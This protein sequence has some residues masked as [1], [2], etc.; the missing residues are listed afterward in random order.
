MNSEE[1]KKLEAKRA[2]LKEWLDRYKN[3]HDAVPFVQTNL[4]LTEWEF[5]A[6]SNMPMKAKGVEIDELENIIQRDYEYVQNAL[7]MIPKYDLNLLK[8]S[9]VVN[10][11]GSQV[12]YGYVARVVDLGTPEAE[13]YSNK[14]VALYQNLQ[15]KQQR[16]ERVRE[17]LVK[18]GNPQTLQRFDTATN[19]YIHAKAD[20]VKRSEAALEMRN[21]LDGVKGDLFEKAREKERENMTW[22]IMAKKIVKPSPIGTEL[23]ELIR[24]GTVRSILYD[25]LSNVLKDREGSSQINLDNIWTELL[26]HIFTVLGLILV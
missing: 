12:V 24:Q 16:P 3:A 2:Y 8:S 5:E 6:L 4:E 25:R 21:L 15:I 9:T 20:T 18:L 26:D 23:A 19:A 22:E 10:T 1:I 11:S 13:Q 14:Y 17:L 7:P